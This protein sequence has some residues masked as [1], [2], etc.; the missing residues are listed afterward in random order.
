MKIEVRTNERLIKESGANLQRGIETVGGRLFLT[1]QRLFFDT[2][3]FNV[4]SGS[5]EIALSD[6][7]YV[8]PIWTKFLGV[9]PLFPNSLR[10]STKQ[11]T[12]FDFVVNGRSAWKSAIELQASIRV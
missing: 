8:I 7:S 6:I 12:F 1:D 2:H 11:G 4:K 10:V 5:E 3:S 9:I